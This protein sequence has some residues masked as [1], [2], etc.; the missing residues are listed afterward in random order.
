[1][2]LTV[3]R[4]FYCPTCKVKSKFYEALSKRYAD[5][6]GRHG[7]YHASVMRCFACDTEIESLRQKAH[8]EENRFLAEQGL[9]IDREFPEGG[10]E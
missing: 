2:S 8:N 7:G 6:E 3:V 10:N 4:N 5:P 1:M 9:I